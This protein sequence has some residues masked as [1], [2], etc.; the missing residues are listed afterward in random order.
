[1]QRNFLVLHQ[2]DSLDTADPLLKGFRDTPPAAKAPAITSTWFLQA[3][4]KTGPPR[5]SRTPKGGK[6]HPPALLTKKNQHLS[7]AT[8]FGK[9]LSKPDR[10]ECC[11]DDTLLTWIAGHI[12]LTTGESCVPSGK[13]GHQLGKKGEGRPSG[14]EE[15]SE[16]VASLSC[17][18]PVRMASSGLVMALPLFHYLLQELPCS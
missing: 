3:G 5:Q 16:V 4:A 11:L 2:N 7:R 8:G 14:W 17:D 9:W 18:E 12:A 13:K 1:V 15:K 6:L 10:S